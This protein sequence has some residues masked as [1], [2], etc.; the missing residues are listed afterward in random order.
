MQK[1]KND[2]VDAVV[3]DL[4][5]DFERGWD[6]LKAKVQQRWDKLTEEDVKAVGG[7]FDELHSRITKS[8]GYDND[9]TNDEISRFVSEGGQNAQRRSPDAVETQPGMESLQ[10]DDHRGVGANVGRDGDKAPAQSKPASQNQY[11]QRPA[12]SSQMRRPASS[13]QHRNPSR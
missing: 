11:A 10:G 12:S 13:D 4:K 1:D 8:Y 6:L 2:N 3:N 9:Q 7:K 5:R